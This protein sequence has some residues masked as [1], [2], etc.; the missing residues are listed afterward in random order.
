MLSNYVTVWFLAPFDHKVNLPGFFFINRENR[1]IRDK[2]TRHS[3]I[4]DYSV[5][6]QLKHLLSMTNGTSKSSRLS[7]TTR[8]FRIRRNAIKHLKHQLHDPL[9]RGD[10]QLKETWTNLLL[11]ILLCNICVGTCTV[12]AIVL[13][14]TYIWFLI[15]IEK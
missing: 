6:F 11:W 9:E 5:C 4:R 12:S 7:Y 14:V 10:M 2:S 8:F 13:K 1:M 15:V 3:R